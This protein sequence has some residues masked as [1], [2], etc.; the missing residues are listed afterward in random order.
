MSVSGN[1]GSVGSLPSQLSGIALSGR[2]SS[3]SALC[4]RYDLSGNPPKTTLVTEQPGKEASTRVDFFRDEPKSSR[5]AL[6]QVRGCSYLHRSS[7]HHA[8]ANRNSSVTRP[9]RLHPTR[10]RALHPQQQ[11]PSR[12]RVHADF[13]PNSSCLSRLHPVSSSASAQLR[14]HVEKSSA[15]FPLPVDRDVEPSDRTLPGRLDV[16][17]TIADDQLTEC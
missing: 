10:L 1:E 16:L 7:P 14:L 4:V 17:F 15:I 12:G 11:A 2:W 8:A 5:S 6:I 13:H 3:R 9:T